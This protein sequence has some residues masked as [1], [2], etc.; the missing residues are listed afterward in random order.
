MKRTLVFCF[1]LFH[2]HP[3]SS[4]QEKIKLFYNSQWEI[5]REENASF[6]REVYYDLNNFKLNGEV[7]DYNIDGTILMEGLYSDGKRNGLFITYYRDGIIESKG[8]YIDNS[9]NG[10]WEY[11][12]R[13]GN[14]KQIVDYTTID[15][16]L[17]F[18]VQEFYDKSGKALISDG[19]GKWTNDSI[20]VGMFDKK[21]YKTLTG[22]FKNSKKIGA[23]RL[24]RLH[25]KRLMFEE[26]F[27]NGEFI[28]ASIYNNR[29]GY[30]GIIRSEILN[31]IPDKNSRK[32]TKTERFALDSL[33]FPQSLI[34]SDVET[35]FT[36][37]TGKEIKIKNRSAGYA[38]GDYSLMAFIQQNIKYPKNAAF[39]NITGT[40]YLKVTINPLGKV[41]DISVIRGVRDDLDNEAIRVIRQLNNWMP[42]LL[43][44]LAIESSI[45]IPIRFDIKL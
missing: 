14:T 39:E 43:D 27:R 9:R 20:Q 32:F 4:A 10:R 30:M 16:K 22:K 19:T 7:K 41:I 23:W 3:D 2:L 34:Y 1:V 12:Y 18:S 29:F 28:D 5:T 26:R 8:N 38:L 13:E 6:Y 25:D 35:I 42:A 37:V 33:Y 15:D 11:F 45:G 40:V 31:K 36:T 21:S 44:G 24:V 17:D